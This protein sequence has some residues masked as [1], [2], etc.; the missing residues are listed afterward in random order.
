MYEANYLWLYNCPADGDCYNFAARVKEDLRILFFV[1]AALIWP[2]CMWN[3]GGK[4][5]FLRLKAKS[6]GHA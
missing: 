1:S 3:L 5:I 6:C 2:V 4:Y